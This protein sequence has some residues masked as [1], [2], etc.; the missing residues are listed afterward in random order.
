[1]K[2]IWYI[3]KYFRGNQAFL[4]QVF[5]YKGKVWKEQCSFNKELLH[6]NWSN[7][8]HKHTKFSE[9]VT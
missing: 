5:T 7:Y 8:I 1:M 4:L 2:Q 9:N 6:F 3:Q